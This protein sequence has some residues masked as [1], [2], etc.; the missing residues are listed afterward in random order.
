MIILLHF[1][2]SR[3]HFLISFKSWRMED[4]HATKITLLFSLKCLY[5]SLGSVSYLFMTKILRHHNGDKGKEKENTKIDIFPLFLA[6]FYK[7]EIFHFSF[8][9]YDEIKSKFEWK[10]QN[11]PRSLLFWLRV[12]EEKSWMNASV[13]SFNT[14]S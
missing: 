14:A 8:A 11:C 13:D 2:A 1:C 7:R 12:K 9:F 10:V 4:F 3:K 5:T 6:S